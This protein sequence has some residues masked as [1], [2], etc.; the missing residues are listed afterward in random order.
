MKLYFS[1]AATLF[2]SS[3]V[4]DVKSHVI[5]YG[6]DCTGEPGAC[7]APTVCTGG[8]CM[9]PAGSLGYMATCTASSECQ[10]GLHCHGSNSMCM[11]DHGTLTYDATCTLDVECAS[12][13][14]VSNKCAAYPAGSLTYD[15]SCS[16]DSECESGDCEAG[17]CTCASSADC[18]E[19]CRMCPGEANVCVL[20]QANGGQCC[21]DTDCTSGYCGGDGLCANRPVLNP[22]LSVNCGSGGKCFAISTTE[23]SCRCEDTWAL[24]MDSRQKPTCTCPT[25]TTL[26]VETNR[27]LA[28]PTMAPTKA[29]TKTPTASPRTS[30][31]TIVP[32]QTLKEEENCFDDES[33]TFILD[34]QS[35]VGCDWLTKNS[36]KEDERKSSYCNRHEVKTLCP[37]SCDFCECKDDP[38]YTFDLVNSGETR[39]CN[40][41]SLNK[42]KKDVRMSKYCTKS[43]DNGALYNACTESCGLCP[44]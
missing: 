26:D 36:I 24:T 13:D 2:L 11:A 40:W 41:L 28:P 31:P 6:A 32:T 33:G 20:I 15:A 37:L 39:H 7:V 43:F 34:N 27:C 25:M 5:P 19:N 17:K 8:I 1:Y 29:P 10:S 42:A 35:V 44:V 18:A 38:T 3:T 14:C 23:A 16:I 30:S 4:L 22:C 9:Q 12:G 21:A